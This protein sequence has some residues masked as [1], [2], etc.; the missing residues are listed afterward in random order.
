MTICLMER[1]WNRLKDHIPPD[2]A[3]Y[4][5]GRGTTK[6][7]FSIKLLAEKAIVSEDYHIHLLLLD[8]SKA[9]DIHLLLLDMAKAFD[10]HLLLLDM[11]KAFATV[12]RKILFEELENVLEDDELH[13]I[14]VI[15][16]RPQFKVKVGNTEGE[17][18][19]T[20]V[21]IMQ[22]DILS[23]MLFIFYL[24][25]SLRKPIKTKMKG[26]LSKP[27]YADDITY[28][29]MSPKQIDELEEK[30]PIRLKEYDLT[31][32]ETKTERYQ[33][34]KPPPAPPKP[35]M[36]SLMQ[37]KDDK[38]LWSELD[39]LVNYKPEIKDK[40]PNWRNCKLLGSKLDSL[41]DFQRRRALTIDSMREMDYVYRSKLLRTQMKIRTFNAFASS[42][43]LYNSELWT[44]TATIEKQID[45]FQRRMLRQTVN[46]RWPKKTS[47]V[48]LHQMTKA[49]KWSNVIKGRRLKWLGH[50]MRMDKQIPVRKALEEAL[51]PAKKR[52]GKPP[53]TWMKAIEKDLNQIIQLNINTH[54]PEQIIQTPESVTKDR[55]QWAH[56]IKD[57]ME[58]NL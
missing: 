11:A 21:G 2:Q 9:F 48:N 5:P 36:E 1:T 54:T 43:F 31:A 47:S 55:K 25:K 32:N 41:K 34:S 53:T 22:G 58:S 35:S 28:A 27:K 37:H 24:A 46:I 57:I 18:F 23:A 15:T 33:I 3:A 30:I 10:I 45:S 49:E 12:N 17:E 50:M 42:V 29:G 40:I 7:V 4:Q 26:F 14:S 56:H 19:E 51:R 44:L 39:W 6:Q 8:M 38:P 16:S 52:R 13:L 20:F